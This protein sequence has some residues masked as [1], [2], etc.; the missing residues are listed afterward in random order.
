[1]VNDVKQLLMCLLFTYVNLERCLFRYFAHYFFK[2]PFIMEKIRN[3]V[4]VP[5]CELIVLLHNNNKPPLQVVLYFYIYN[6]LY[7]EFCQTGYKR[8]WFHFCKHACPANIHRIIVLKVY[9]FF[10]VF[11]ISLIKALLVFRKI[12]VVFKH[13]GCIIKL[14]IGV[15]Y[16][17]FL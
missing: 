6:D 5:Q 7:L 13:V 1:M 16:I 4:K 3:N 17:S 15:S 11:L 2:E 8:K 9:Y 14:K 12:R 10:S